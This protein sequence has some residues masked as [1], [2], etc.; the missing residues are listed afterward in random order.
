MAV[1]TCCSEETSVTVE[2]LQQI[3]DRHEEWLIEKS[4]NIPPRFALSTSILLFSWTLFTVIREGVAIYYGNFGFPAKEIALKKSNPDILVLSN[5]PE[6]PIVKSGNGDD[7]SIP[8]ITLLSEML[9]KQSWCP[10]WHEAKRHQLNQNTWIRISSI[11]L[12]WLPW[13]H[14]TWNS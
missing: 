13:N 5:N 4:V 2:Y 14:V 3:H 10:N 12:C 7:P 9:L 1:T 11:Q 8:V 6:I